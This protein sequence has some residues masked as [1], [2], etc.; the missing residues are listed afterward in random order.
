M[1]QKQRVT[2][3]VTYAV[4]LRKTSKQ[5]LMCKIGGLSRLMLTF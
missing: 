3:F 1:Q 4:V 5:T 2:A